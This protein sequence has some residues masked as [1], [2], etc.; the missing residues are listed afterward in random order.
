MWR[1]VPGLMKHTRGPERGRAL[2]G[3]ME[4]PW[5][6]PGLQCLHTGLPLGTLGS[7]WVRMRQRAGLGD[8]GRRRSCDPLEQKSG[9]LAQASQQDKAGASVA[10]WLALTHHL[11][12]HRSV[13][14]SIP[15]APSRQ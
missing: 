13:R 3:L 8:L 4:M 10:C 12:L 5:Q 15:L 9:E 2:P 7:P 1:V 11:A 14:N 6:S